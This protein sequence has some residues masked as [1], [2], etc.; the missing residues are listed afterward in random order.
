MRTRYPALSLAKEAHSR[1]SASLSVTVSILIA[2]IIGEKAGAVAAVGLLVGGLG[3]GG[4]IYSLGVLVSANGQMLLATLDTALN[5]S[6]LLDVDEKR[7]ILLDGPVGPTVTE[8]PAS[9]SQSSP[10][11]EVVDPSKCPRCGT[12]GKATGTSG[13]WSCGAHTWTVRR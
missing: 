3:F 1:R 12:A 11:H 13:V 4:S 8:G 5:T 7:A 6:P 10:E 2:M 9:S